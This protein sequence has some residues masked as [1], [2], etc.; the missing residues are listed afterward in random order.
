MKYTSIVAAL[1]L[2]IGCQSGPAKSAEE[3]LPSFKLLTPDSTVRS[4]TALIKE[5]SPVAL[6]YFSPGCEHCQE[7]TESII[8]NMDSLKHVQFCFITTDALEEMRGFNQYY[9]LYKYPNITIGR[10]EEF[11]FLRHFKGAFPPYIV[12]YD[13][14]KRQREVFKGSIEASRLI[15][16]IN[17]L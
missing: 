7:E 8:H 14:D 3:L 11:F 2:L 15:A 16:T 5:G 4:D 10:D 6:L 13:K 9:K 1:L 12:I 17:H